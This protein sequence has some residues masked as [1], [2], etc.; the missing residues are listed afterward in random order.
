MAGKLRAI[1]SCLTCL[2]SYCPT[3]LRPHLENRAFH[4]HRLIAPVTDIE[5]QRCPRHQRPLHFFCST[6]QT[7]VCERCVPEAHTQHQLLTVTAAR[8]QKQGEL[9]ESQTKIEK[10]LKAVEN[11]I[12]KLQTNRASIANSVSEVKSCV[13]KQFNEV[14]ECVQKARLEVMEFL[15]KEEGASLKQAEGIRAHLEQKCE[16]LR[17][18]KEQMKE[19]GT[20]KNT[21]Q[22]LQ[23]FCEWKKSHG[24][25]LLPSVYIG[26]ID[27]LAGIS[28]TVCETSDSIKQLLQTSYREK[29]MTCAKA[30]NCGF[31]T[32][33]AVICPAEHWI[34]APQPTSVS[35]FQK[36]AVSLVFDSNTAHKYL[37]LV[38]GNRKVSNTSPWLQPY[39]EDPE[40]FEHWRQILCTESFYMARSY[41]EVTI[42]GEGTYVGVTYKSIDRKGAESNSCITGNDFSWCLQWTG[43]DFSAWHGDTEVSGLAGDF[44][45]IGVYLD[46]RGRSLAFYGVAAE[47][48]TLLYKFNAVFTEPLYPAFYLSKKE[49][50]VS[51][52]P[53]EKDPGQDVT[54]QQ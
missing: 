5:R 33:V 1:R 29:L 38:E 21:V 50:T 47:T 45:R 49:A 15:E 25:D 51:L 4:T 11:A 9:L 12:E 7:C 6:D 52:L 26:L 34:T 54:V 44:H 46:Y 48:M 18:T 23:E 24:D 14:T 2:V 42:S 43:R 31:K 32:T 13:E 41:W 8:G 37:R 3:H 36:Y 17:K 39:P 22:F 16:E 30:E 40:R 20:R 10:K 35:D 53:A 28:K 19:L 27:K